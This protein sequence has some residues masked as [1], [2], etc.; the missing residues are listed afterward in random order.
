MHQEPAAPGRTPSV[1]RAARALCP[2]TDKLVQQVLAGTSA[3]D[4]TTHPL[5]A[6]MVTKDVTLW[7][8]VLAGDLP[9]ATAT[10][11]FRSRA[12]AHAAAGLPV[13][14]ALMLQQTCVTVLV[15]ELAETAHAPALRMTLEKA[16]THVAM[17]ELQT[18][19]IAVVRQYQRRAN[20]SD[21]DHAHSGPA[22]QQAQLGPASHPQWCLAASL[23]RQ[24][25]QEALRRFR[26]ENPEARIG[27][28]GD[29]VSAFTHHRPAAA[30]TFGP[31]A[32]IRIEQ[33]DTSRAARRAALAAV[34][35]Q[36]YGVCVDTDH[37][38]PL[39]AALDVAARD[40]EAFAATCL[41]PL[42]TEDRY[43]HL[44]ETL[45]AYLAH[46]LCITAAARSL[47][48]HR[49]TFTY[50]LHS[51]RTLTGL[52]LNNPYDRLRAE[53]ALIL[54]GMHS[55]WPVPKQRVA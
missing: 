15:R 4:A 25:G 40:R 44:L 50:R 3:M 49:H 46:N 42:H 24:G 51:I 1:I 37:A 20:V 52:D 27:V 39:I 31:Y 36:H 22:T 55:T 21:P 34:I 19:S 10:T 18:A 9:P 17:R 23:P 14:Q 38:L 29:R 43:R 13:E 12:A 47:Y 30:D 45:A 8:A 5:S 48:V 11:A 7:L 28:T 53:F 2:R 35:A 16:L 54:S 26:N 41:G 6:Q 33:G 32:L